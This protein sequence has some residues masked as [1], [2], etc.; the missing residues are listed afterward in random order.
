VLTLILLF[1][2]APLVELYVIVAVAG[3]I[4]WLPTLA[5]LAASTVA[6]VWLTKVE[7]LGVLR[8]MRTTVDQGQLPADEAIDGLLISVG[9]LLMIVPGFI[10]TFLG[11]ILMVPPIRSQLRPVVRHRIERRAARAQARMTYSVG[12]GPGAFGGDSFGRDPFGAAGGDGGPIDVD[13]HVWSDPPSS[14]SSRPPNLPGDLPEL[15]S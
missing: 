5:F 9:G 14:G 4:G 7:G 15:G 1:V 11:L 6:G 13:S 12:F 8:R 3:A 10:S 2:V